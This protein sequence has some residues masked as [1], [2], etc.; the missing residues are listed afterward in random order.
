MTNLS[1]VI[2]INFLKYIF[3]KEVT[4]NVCYMI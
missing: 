4:K 2:E 1:V 3:E